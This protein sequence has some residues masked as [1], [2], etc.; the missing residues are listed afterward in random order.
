MRGLNPPN[1]SEQC[2]A[3]IS[4]D[5]K[6]AIQEGMSKE[7]ITAGLVY[8]ICL[9]Y[10]NRVKG[11]RSVGKK[12]FM[13]GGVCYNKSIPVAMAALTGKKIIVPPE[14]GLMG[15]FGVALDIKNKINL[16]LLEEQIFDLN[17]LKERGAKYL[18]PFVCPGGKEKCDLKCKINRI[19]MNGKVYPFG[20]ACNKYTSHKSTETQIDKNDFDYVA[21]REKLVFDK[22]GVNFL[23]EP[24]QRT[25]KTIGINNSLLVNSLFPLYYNFFNSSPHN[26]LA[27]YNNHP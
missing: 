2:S 19:E 25:N 23:K 26:N 7:E 9:N 11:N 17:E 5:I 15:A 24:V 22:Y 4:S 1:F 3:F 21:I 14:P 12:I 13:Q 6:R 18:D 10:I 16:G 27:S 8:S 20:G